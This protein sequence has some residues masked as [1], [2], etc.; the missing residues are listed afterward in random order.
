MGVR[1]RR[2]VFF[3]KLDKLGGRSI[4]KEDIPL[5]PDIDAATTLSVEEVAEL[6]KEMNALDE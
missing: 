6:T 1:A 5:P 4:T 2:R 3:C